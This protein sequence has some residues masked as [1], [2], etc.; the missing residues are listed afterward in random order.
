ME[1]E[2]ATTTTARVVAGYERAAATLIP[3]Y[4]AFSTP[5]LLEPVLHLLPPAPRSVLD[6][7]AGTGRDA[8]WFARHGARV[9]AVEPVGPFRRAGRSMHPSDRIIWVDDTLP[10]LDRVP[11]GASGFDVILLNGVWHHLAPSARGAAIVSLRER[12]ALSGLLVVSLRHGPAPSQRPG[13]D[14]SAD[15]TAAAFDQLGLSLAHREARGSIQAANQA[16]GVTW[17]WLALRRR[18]E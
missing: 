13:F 9:L 8:A 15:H 4:E 11:A 1:R 16:L 17:T 3:R 14:V 18:D 2:P 6:V 5:G 12:L 10:S 7:G